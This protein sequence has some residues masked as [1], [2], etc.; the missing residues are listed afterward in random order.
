MYE[1][2]SAIQNNLSEEDTFWLKRIYAPQVVAI[3]PSDATRN[4]CVTEDGEI[5]LYGAEDFVVW[6]NEG[7]PVYLASRDGGLTWKKKRC[8]ENALRCAGV[9]RKTGRYIGI[10]SEERD[11]EMKRR[12]IEGTW[13]ILNDTGFDG[14][15]N[16]WLQLSELSMEILKLPY[17]SETMNR[18]FVFCQYRSPEHVRIPVVFYSDDDGESWTESRLKTPAPKHE[19]KPPHKGV[20]WQQY[21]CEPTVVEL[22]DTE[23]Y[24]I[25]RTS[26][27]YHYAYHSYD[28]GESWSEPERTNFHGTITMPVLQK[29]SD[30]RIVFFWCNNQPLPEVD[31]EATFP[32]LTEDERTGVWEDVFTN[33]DANHLAISE[34]NGKTWIG[35]RELYLNSRRN[36][37]DFRSAGGQTGVDRS[38]HQGQILEL[39]Y[40]KLL[41]V[42]GQ[43]PRCRRAVIVDINW[44]YETD[45]SED[46]VEGL[47]NVS[48][49]L[50]I[51]SVLGGKR[52][53]VLPGH[54][55]YNRTHGALPAPD[56][57]GDFSE[58]LRVC[59]IKD[60][61]LVDDRQGVVWNYPATVTG[62][63]TVTLRVQGS[64]VALSLTD[65]WYNPCDGTVLDEAP[66]TFAYAEKKSDVHVW[67]TVTFCYDTGKRTA[68]VLVN[69][70]PVQTLAMRG[71]APNG[72]SYLHIRTLAEDNDPE[73]TLLKKL[74]KIR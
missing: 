51:K 2:I 69:G 32:R 25:V 20:R 63:V 36:D 56:P 7:F 73:G 8:D 68:Q 67:D 41:I 66:F 13:I 64:G 15:D 60:D 21:S 24:M 3:P 42:F 44:L 6:Q 53:L 22:S 35:M 1:Y 12:G 54:C 61:R 62:K 11:D 9:N 72:L 59:R 65:H 28:R 5:R 18:W 19:A 37:P 26:Q 14:T 30:G 71:E 58:V 74:E 40:G 50:Y 34:D 23:L 17:F 43:H 31:H 47:Q 48:T 46:F 29:L 52:G 45:R 70:E 55:A 49:Q 57:V 33:R 38:I 16:R 27:D 4:M 10:G 39:P